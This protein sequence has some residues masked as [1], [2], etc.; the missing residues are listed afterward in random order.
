LC[1]TTFVMASVWRQVCIAVFL[2]V[3]VTFSMFTDLGPLCGERNLRPGS[4]TVFIWLLCDI[5]WR[6]PPHLAPSLLL[7]FKV[8]W[9][10]AWNLRKYTEPKW[11][12]L[13]VCLCAYRPT[14]YNWFL[15]RPLSIHGKLIINKISMYSA[16]I[17]CWPLSL[18]NKTNHGIFRSRSSGLWGDVV[19][20]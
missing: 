12:A 20:R 5:L 19:L 16:V 6:M 8:E 3:F 15:R 18:K 11:N 17:F 4:R 7:K 9:Y 2:F 13:F 14:R 10:Y 1:D